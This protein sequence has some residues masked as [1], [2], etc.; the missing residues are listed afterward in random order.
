MLITVKPRPVISFPNQPPICSTAP[1]RQL[2]ATPSGGLWSGVGVTANGLF[3]PAATG[4]GQHVT[5][6]SVNQN[7]CNASKVLVTNV[8]AQPTLDVGGPETVCFSTDQ[9]LLTGLPAGGTWSGNGVNNDGFFIPGFVSPG[10]TEVLTYLVVVDGCTAT[11]IKQITVTL[12]TLSVNAGTDQVVCES[13]PAFV[14]AGITVAGG[15]W[16]GT[17][18]SSN[19]VFNPAISGIGTFN[20]TYNVTFFQ[21]PL[22][23]GSDIKSISVI[24][25]P[26]APS[27]QNDTIC[28]EGAGILRAFGT[29]SS[30]RWYTTALG[31]NALSGQVLPV[32]TTPVLN[33]S[34]TYYVSE[35]AGNCESPRTSVQAFVNNF[36][37]ASFSE[38]GNPVIL[39]ANPSTGQFYQWLFAGIPIN[40]AN[41]K[42]FLPTQNG[43][44]S[45]VIG[46][47]GC[48][49]TSAVQFVTV[50]NLAENLP[51]PFWKIYPNPVRDVL[52]LEGE[53]IEEVRL[54][55][56]LGQIMYQSRIYTFCQT[57]QTKDLPN[58]VYWLEIKNKYRVEKVKVVVRK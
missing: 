17:G 39:N 8:S 21:S 32:Y 10:N 6:Y 14:L 37:N 12:N 44:Y 16:S 42:S 35:K 25:S 38:S 54:L 20:L 40:G 7:G 56:V 5:S 1:G 47:D 58:G 33:A 36:N 13:D 53:G 29:G 45:V 2:S 41:Q 27:V 24:G 34:T 31:G 11:K 48:A 26:Q 18:V 15:S 4:P 22:C 50:T 23:S 28:K 43:D 3:N 19:G 51:K 46:F 30:F 9:V 55:N 52:F 57:L 49:D